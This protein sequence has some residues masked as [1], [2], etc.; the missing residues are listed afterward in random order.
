MKI[1][2]I[3]NQKGGVGKSTT[4]AALVT[5]LKRKGKKVLAIDLDAQGNLS[6]TFIADMEKPTSFGVLLRENKAKAA[7]QQTEQ[8]DIIPSSKNMI[9]ADM[10]LVDTGKE[11]LLKE[12]IEPIKKNYDYIVIDTPPVLG[13]LT[14]N[15]LTASDAIIIPIQADLYSLQGIGLI[16]D[17]IKQVKKYTN[18]KLKIEGILLT[19]FTTRNTLSK[20]VL[21][22]TAEIAEKLN[23]KLFT[24]TIREA[25]SIKE[26]QF[27]RQDIYSYAPKSKVAE[28][29]SSLVD[30]LLE[31]K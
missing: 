5:G 12:A 8:G 30:E 2:S 11:Y 22:L 25:V 18:P 26:A 13:I 28:D 20:E 31:G 17:T 9:A 10:V 4:A 3:V 15:A 29:Y 23:T 27:K 16:I 21:E 7:I 24:S 6:N 14:I 1:I 19:R